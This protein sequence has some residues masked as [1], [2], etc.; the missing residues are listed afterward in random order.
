MPR[1]KKDETDTIP[2]AI[3][4]QADA[5]DAL[6]KKILEGKNA[7]AI[8]PVKPVE[9]PPEQVEPVETP[10]VDVFVPPAINDPSSQDDSA[11]KT[12]YDV[13]KG[14]YDSEVPALQAQ[15]RSLEMVTANMQ[16]AIENQL[17]A[18]ADKS[19]ARVE[20]G[21]KPLNPE[22]YEEYGTE[23]V[24]LAQSF[25]AIL[26]QNEKL[27]SALNN[28]GGGDFSDLAKRTERL[29]TTFQQTNEE[30]YF[31]SLTNQ[32]SDWRTI[33]KSVQFDQWLNQIDPI[34]MAARRDI[35]Q[36]AANTL[37]AQ[38]VVNIFK[39]FKNDSGMV[40]SGEANPS[41]VVK[42]DHLSGH[43]MP[44]ANVSNPNEMQPS[45]L[46][47]I[48]PTTT[49]FNKASTDFVLKRITEEQY[50]DIANRYQMAIKAG[51]LQS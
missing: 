13:L 1:K 24:T 41:Q 49:E 20:S 22:N 10:P 43:V 26:E 47:V 12:R 15:I 16:T 6:Q 9:T 45:G 40:R 23:I 35:L 48:Y 42:N 27:A 19:P 50:N 2:P 39:Q 21:I 31:D 37:N 38:Q 5:A 33:N 8:D 29:E 17:K 36:Y 46:Q 28:K 44:A 25:N 4:K 18:S 14:K 32:V 3:Q 34:S 11:Y 7:Q 51:K 30:K